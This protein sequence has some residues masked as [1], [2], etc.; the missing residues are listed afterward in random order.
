MPK[1]KL[2]KRKQQALATHQKIYNTALALFYKKGYDKVTIDDICEKAGV[3]KGAFYDHF[4]SKDQVIIDL[5][6]MADAV[7]EEYASTELP[8]H[9]KV[10]DKL[11]LLGKKGVS[12]SSDMGI[13]IIQVSY[14]S[15]INLNEKTAS[16]AWERR[17][18]YKL[19]QKLV[20]E[21]QA[22][23]E[24]RKDFSKEDITR[25]VLR[26]VRGV[27]YDWCLVRGRFDLVK[28]AE[29]AFAVLL[30]GLRPD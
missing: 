21:G 19:I 20:E 29:K 5:F 11:F 9:K 7:Y 13:D 22:K 1:N 18:L 4:K 25:L 14:R 15:Q 8:R 26:C 28:E 24:I 17:A 16:I 30:K 23:G 27:I 3:S 10:T 2:T 12:Y 6:L